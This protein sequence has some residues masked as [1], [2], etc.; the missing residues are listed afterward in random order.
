[1]STIKR[2]ATYGVLVFGAAT[3]IAPL[4]WMVSTSLKT[5]DDVLAG[6]ALWVPT[7]PQW[8]NYLTA[9]NAMPF[10]R[11][12]LN[13]LFVAVCVTVCQVLTSAMAGYAFARLRFPGRDKLFVGYLATMMVPHSVVMIPVFVLIAKLGWADTYKA[14]ILP[15]AFTP[16]GTF[17]LRQF[18]IGIPRELEEA[19]TID[20]CNCGGVF[21]RIILPLSKPA[22]ATLATLTFM[23]NWGSFMWPLIVIKSTEKKTLPIGLESFQGPYATEWH[24]LMA[25]SV[26]VMA[27]VVILFLINQRFITEG[28]KMGGFGG[29]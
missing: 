16:F 27:P 7:D 22:L 17:M 3:M 23:A 8:T 11:F 2:I 29:T 14:L 10:G 13:S 4:L 9:W 12:Y 25:A 28:V 21:L 15:V 20:G 19:A 26:I 5:L 6:D 1:M 24:L 18:F